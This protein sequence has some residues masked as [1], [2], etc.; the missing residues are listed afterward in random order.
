MPTIEIAFVPGDRV[1]VKDRPERPGTEDAMRHRVGKD[2]C[3]TVWGIWLSRGRVEEF[4]VAFGEPAALA[5]A[6]LGH[7]TF[8]AGDLEADAPRGAGA[9]GKTDGEV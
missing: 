4:T 8:W 7:W 5:A 1:C 2:R 6:L 9:E 3:G